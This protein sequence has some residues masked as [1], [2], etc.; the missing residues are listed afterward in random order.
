MTSTDLPQGMA[1]HV[2]PLSFGH[3]DPGALPELELREAMA[4]VMGGPQATAALQYGA[5]Q[6]TRGLIEFLVEKLRHEQQLSLT[7]AHL[8]IVAGSTHA[9]DMI[10]RLYAKP[11]SV[12]L[13]EAPTYGDSLHVLRDQR[14]EVCP[15]AMDEDG[16]I[17]AALAEQ[18]ERLHAR[19]TYPS[20]LY[21]V[22]TF[23]NPTGRTLTE[24]RRLDLLDLARQ[25]DFWIVEDDVYRDLSFVEN[26]PPSFATLAGG[27]HVLSIGSFSKTLAPGLRL[28]WLLAPEAEIQRCV[29]CG[30]IQMGGGAN[31]LVAHAVAEYCQSGAWE[32]HIQRLRS[33]YRARRDSMLAALERFMPSGVT[34]THP[35]GGFFI[36]LSLPEY[37]RSA[38]IKQMALQRG[39][40]LTAGE[41]FFVEPAAGTHHL[42]LTYSCATPQEIEAGVSVLARIL[43]ELH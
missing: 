41:G 9:V 25:H 34:W 42:R 38:E 12:V 7:G 17:P 32:P 33:L 13:V 40:A 16:L 2:I 5:E 26:V 10:A 28:G 22:P 15:V 1:E 4:R 19:G 27:K 24:A 37:A 43:R 21:T 39:V 29:E 35:Q 31:P 23:H 3:P 36:W 6:G 11:G 14:A 30:I 8:M 20:L 18:I